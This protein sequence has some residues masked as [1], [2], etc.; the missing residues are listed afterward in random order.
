[1]SL[2]DS[3]QKL[4]IRKGGIPSGGVPNKEAALEVAAA[5][6]AD[7]DMIGPVPVDIFKQY[8]KPVRAHMGRMSKE[9]FRFGIPWDSPWAIHPNNN[10]DKVVPI[11]EEMKQENRSMY[12]EFCDDYPNI[13]EDRVARA[14][15]L[16]TIDM[17]PSA[18]ELRT[19][20]YIEIE[21]GNLPDPSTDVRA[22]WSHR[23]M[24]DYKTAVNRQTERYAKS[25]VLTLLNEVKRPIHNIVDKSA[26]YDGG[27]EG[28]WST[29]TFIGNV[30]EVVDKMIPMNFADDPEIEALRKEIISDICGL[31]SKELREDKDLLKD[32]GQKAQKIVNKTDKIINRVAQFGA[33]LTL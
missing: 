31:D 19:K 11:L 7:P 16:V 27:R 22:G 33:G 13:L 20:W 30:Q 3:H 17:F 5:H 21:R 28:R 15:D 6:G 24:E 25:A 10:I 9:N 14:G 18:D 29:D 23:Q 8:V 12:L 1:M 26:R 32:A 2:A 4:A